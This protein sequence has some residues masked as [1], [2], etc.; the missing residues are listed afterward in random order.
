MEVWWVNPTSILGSSEASVGHVGSWCPPFSGCLK[1]NVSGAYRDNK[2]GCG[3]I[4]KNKYGILRALFSGPN[5]GTSLDSAKLV[6]IKVT[7]ELFLEA[8]WS[9]VA[10]LVI[11]VDSQQFRVG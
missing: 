10:G 8:N 1:F 2:A 5:K 6:A 11:E 7:L 9:G 3:R 4:L